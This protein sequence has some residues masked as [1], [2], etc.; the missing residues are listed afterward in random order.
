VQRITP[1]FSSCRQIEPDDDTST[2][3]RAPST[4]LFVTPEAS[5]QDE[6]ALH[7][8]TSDVFALGLVYVEILAVILGR[9]VERLRQQVFV[10]TPVGRQQYHKVVESIISY[11]PVFVAEAHPIQACLER[12]LSRDRTKRPT[13]KEF[14]RL[15]ITNHCPS[16]HCF[17]GLAQGWW[18]PCA[19]SNIHSFSH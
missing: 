14:L 5:P 1:E 6:L 2:L 8:S 19:T 4:R 16:C 17:R 7:G 11:L 13:A 10:D 15:L 12:M 9:T 3:S 18:L